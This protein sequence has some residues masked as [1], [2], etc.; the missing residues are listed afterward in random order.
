MHIKYKKITMTAFELKI[1]VQNETFE[2]QWTHESFK[3]NKHLYFTLHLFLNQASVYVLPF[4]LFLSHYHHNYL[5]RLYF[6]Y[7]RSHKQYKEF[8]VVSTGTQ[9][10]HYCSVG[11]KTGFTQTLSLKKYFS[12]SCRILCHI[13]FF[14]GIYG[15]I[16]YRHVYTNR[17]STCFPC[18][19]SSFFLIIS[20]YPWCSLRW[21]VE[22]EH[23]EGKN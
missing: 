3:K 12:H 8:K 1:S 16:L 17:Y 7:Y 23:G 20:Y 6:H 13:E 21:G 15:E 11:S 2:T 10:N 22:N 4:W 19:I 14:C 5:N 18:Q 9:N